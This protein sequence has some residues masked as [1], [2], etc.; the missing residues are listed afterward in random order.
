MS[1]T[2]LESALVVGNFEPSPFWAANFLKL[3]PFLSFRTCEIS[4]RLKISQKA[5]RL[6][7]SHF[8][9]IFNRFYRFITTSSASITSTEQWKFQMSLTLRCCE[10][11]HTVLIFAMCK[12]FVIAAVWERKINFRFATRASVALVWRCIHLLPLS[13]LWR[14]KKELRE[15]F[16][17]L[18]FIF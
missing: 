5:F 13:S 17:H 11:F 6:K 4:S 2:H 10:T 18:S 14:H 3:T 15:L 7:I 8:N 16:L 12:S 9:L 1:L